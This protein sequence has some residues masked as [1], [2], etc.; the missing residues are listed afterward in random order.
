MPPRAFVWVMQLTSAGF[1]AAATSANLLAV[2]YS[3]WFAA[4]TQMATDASGA[5]YL[6]ASCP[7]SSGSAC[8]VTKLSAD[9]KTIP[10][11]DVPGFQ[12]NTMAVSPSGDVFVV[13]VVQPSD[14]SLYV[15]KLGAAGSGVA[16]EAAAGF[17]P[18]ANILWAPVL[19]ADSQG[20]AY[21]AALS[22]T[23]TMD[24]AGVGV[25][26][27]VRINAAGSGIDYAPP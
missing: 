11:Q 17:L 6:L 4:A 10:W 15:A 24:N 13:P 27:V 7:A 25:T 21:V 22:G 12:T 26:T 23:T 18:P 14:T 19:T 1:A 2:D 5:L 16:W 20:R 9:G 8:C 3:E